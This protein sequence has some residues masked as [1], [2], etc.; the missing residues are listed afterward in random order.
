MKQKNNKHSA[1]GIRWKLFGYLAAFTAVIVLIL[2]L[3]QVVF[4]EDIYRTV[5][6]AEIKAAAVGLSHSVN[7]SESLADAAGVISEKNDVCVLVLE[8]LDGETAKKLVSCDAVRNCAIHNMSMSGYFKLYDSAK[9][10]GGKF[11]QHYR[12]DAKS[13]AYIAISPGDNSGDPES[14]IYAFTVHGEN[15][16]EVLFILNSVV[17]P[18]G[19][20]VRTLNFLLI[21]VS[22]VMIGLAL[23][24]AVLISRKISMPII[25]INNSAKALAEGKYDVRFVGGSYREISELSDTLNYAATELSKVDGLR[26]ELIAN[27]SHDLRTPLTMITGYAEIMRD[28]PGEATPEIMQIVIDET[29]RLTTLVN[30]MLEVSRYQNGTQKLNVTH[31][32]LTNVIRTTIERYAK[33]R[34]KDG[35]TI[36][37]ESDRDVFVNADEQRILQVI[38]NL[39]GNAVNYAGEDK[40]VIIRQTVENGEVL[41]EV[42]DHGIGIPED[43]L[44]MVWERYYK[45]NDFHKRANIGTGLGLSI[46]KNILLLHGAQFGVKSKVGEGSN[47]WFKLKTAD[48]AP[49]NK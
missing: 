12:Y 3:C 25:D 19:A 49:D 31:F 1:G 36:K 40:T 20:T 29:N 10:N 7:D 8:M 48:E 18:V 11:L 34:E 28:L 43:Q 44:P 30:D 42:I 27:T 32:N 16:H 37:F 26:R 15:G 47:F 33:L 6:T 14:I 2:W 38:Y 5:K 45:V 46:V 17:S 9:A 24:L 39:I 23:L 35:Y 22:V 21:A 4:L 13:R 41:L